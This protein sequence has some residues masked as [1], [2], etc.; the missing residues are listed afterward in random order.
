MLLQ[1]FDFQFK[2]S[3][4]VVAKVYTT[5]SSIV[6]LFKEGNELCVV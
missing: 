4:N 5:F 1:S 6:P 2:M 3:K